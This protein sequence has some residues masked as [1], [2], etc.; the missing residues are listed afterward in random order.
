M[1]DDDKALVERLR[2]PCFEIGLDEGWIDA[3][4]AKA[5]DRIEADGR[6]IAALKRRVEQLKS[7]FDTV[8][9]KLEKA[10]T[11]LKGMK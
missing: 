9:K 11:E 3:Q 8:S 5:A 6:Q 1:S 4:R 7:M 2:V 10:H